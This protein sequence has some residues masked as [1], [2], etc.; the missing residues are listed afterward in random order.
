MGTHV[1]HRERR[2][3]AR[4]VDDLPDGAIVRLKPACV[5]DLTAPTAVERRL[6]EDHKR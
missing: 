5:A 3:W 4:R 1:Q 2:H 6:V